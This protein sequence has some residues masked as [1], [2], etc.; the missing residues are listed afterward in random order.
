MK[1][2]KKKKRKKCSRDNRVKV[3]E[4]EFFSSFPQLLRLSAGILKDFLPPL[5]K[6]KRGWFFERPDLTVSEIFTSLTRD[7]RDDRKSRD[8]PTKP[9]ILTGCR[10]IVTI[11]SISQTVSKRHANWDAR[12]KTTAVNPRN[13]I[14][15]VALQRGRIDW[16]HSLHP[17]I[18]RFDVT[19]TPR[20]EH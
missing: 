9:A 18:S 10:I 15:E 8:T 11:N 1:K 13:R 17:V 14:N 2:E 19:R 6:K 7:K 16:I 5:L 3:W 4:K 12:N 20:D